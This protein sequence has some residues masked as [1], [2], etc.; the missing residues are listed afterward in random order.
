MSRARK[1]PRATDSR[2]RPVRGLY[3]RDGSYF[4][5]ARVEA[6][7]TMRRLDAANLSEARRERD[8]WISDLRAGRTAK[9]NGSTFGTVFSE[10]QES[11]SK[12]LSERTAEHERHLLRRHLS[13]LTDRRIQEID[14]RAVARV[15]RDVRTQH[16]EWTAVACLRIL[17]GVFS[18][19]KRHK[20]TTEN[21]CDQLADYEKPSQ[22]NAREI[23]VLGRARNA[24]VSWLRALQRD[25]A[26]L[27]PSALS[28]VSASV[29]SAASSG[30]TWTLRPR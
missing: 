28:K 30:A 27:S 2:G 22:K 17:N 4:A 29:R 6:R 26:L 18:F 9:R 20:I 13:S 8:A 19:G 24:F 1:F 16:S 3:E 11:R 25:G 15:V 23:R 21:P 7:W 12:T 10:W 5:G 14:S